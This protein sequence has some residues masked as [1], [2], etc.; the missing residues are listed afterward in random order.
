VF[1]EKPA[2]HRFPVMMAKRVRQLCRMIGDEY[3]NDG[4]RVWAGVKKADELYARM[5]ELPGFGDGKAACAVRILATFGAQPTSG[6]QR[7]ATPADMPW[8]FKDGVRES[9]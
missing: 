5:R 4:K 2:I 6:W 8:V 3:R 1:R 9:M 7:Y